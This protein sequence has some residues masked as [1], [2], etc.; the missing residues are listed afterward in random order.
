MALAYLVPAGVMT[1]RWLSSREPSP[2]I[3][4]ASDVE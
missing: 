1:V 4:Q 3:D 2:P